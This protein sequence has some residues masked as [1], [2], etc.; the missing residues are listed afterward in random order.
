MGRQRIMGFYLQRGIVLVYAVLL[1][2]AGAIV[3]ADRPGAP[4]GDPTFPLTSTIIFYNLY[5]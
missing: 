1:L 5:I 2:V 3:A 4:N